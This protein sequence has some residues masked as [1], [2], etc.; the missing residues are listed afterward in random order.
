MPLI[1]R[2]YV[3]IVGRGALSLANVPG[4]GLIN[5]D[6]Q[7]LEFQVGVP[8]MEH[9]KDAFARLAERME[10]V[11]AA[12]GGK[13]PAAEIPRG[14]GFKRL[15]AGRLARPTVLIGECPVGSQKKDCGS[16][17]ALPP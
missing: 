7:P 2:A 17:Q 1:E 8:V 6:G 9:E 16:E 5:I 15:G 10:R 12:L 13:R 4:R 14:V 3:D 11:W